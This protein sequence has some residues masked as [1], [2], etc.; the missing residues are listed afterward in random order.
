MLGKQLNFLKIFDDKNKADDNTDEADKLEKPSTEMESNLE[1]EKLEI[2]PSELR[3]EGDSESNSEEAGLEN[4]LEEEK[5]QTAQD[6]EKTRQEIQEKT[7]KDQLRADLLRDGYIPDLKEFAPFM[8]EINKYQERYHQIE[9]LF[10][11]AKPGKEKMR[12]YEL[13]TYPDSQEEEKYLESAKLFMK[14]RDALRENKK[15]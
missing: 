5:L 1:K 13:L 7:D 11:Q 15:Y 3:L 14:Y 10:K 4:S 12:V 9:E 8:E 2:K 6:L